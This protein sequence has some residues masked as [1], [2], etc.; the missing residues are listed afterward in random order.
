MKV[1]AQT[2]RDHVKYWCHKYRENTDMQYMVQ[3]GLEGGRMKKLMGLM[4]DKKIR[5]LIDFA[6]SGDPMTA[7][8]RQQGFPIA[9]FVSQV[10]KYQVAVTNPGISIPEWELN[11]DIPVWDDKRTS[12]LW[13]RIKDSDMDSILKHIIK[14]E[15]W[16]ILMAK[17]DRQKGFIPEKVKWFYEKWRMKEPIKR[18]AIK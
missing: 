9:L 10:N 17:L 1:Y 13:N 5:A 12:Y 18:E 8:L 15:A 2:S 11:L 3:W 6:F 7:Y 4:S 16:L 14:K